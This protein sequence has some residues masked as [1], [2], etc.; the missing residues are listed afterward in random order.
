MANY[1][2]RMGSDR[3]DPKIFGSYSEDDICMHMPL[4][5]GE[6]VED[7]WRTYQPRSMMENLNNRTFGR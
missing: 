3:L 7:I 6:Y 2:E 5:E 4:D 1:D